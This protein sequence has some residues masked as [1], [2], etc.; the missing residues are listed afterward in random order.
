MSI[1]TMIGDN[2]FTTKV[3]EVAN[4]A[5]K[6]SL[7]P[8]PF[9]TACCAIEYMSVVSSHYDVSRFGAEVV[10]FSP[11]QSDLLM[12]MGTITDKMGPI[13]KKIYDQMSD[14]KWVISMGACATS[15]GFYRAYHV[16][17]GIDEII[18]VDVY[19]PGC[20]P[21]P[22][23]VIQAILMI[24]KLIEGEKEID[25]EARAELRERMKKEVTESNP[26][27]LLIAGQQAQ[28]AVRLVHITREPAAPENPVVAA[29]KKD[30]ADQ[31]LDVN[32]FRGDL[33]I[34]LRPDRITA[35]CAALKEEPTTR[36][37]MLST[38]TGVDYQGYP[39]KTRDERFNIVYQLYSVEHGHRVR[40]KV[41]VP[42]SAPEVDSVTPVWKTANWWERETFDMFGINFRRH[43]D[44]RRI[45]CHEEFVGHALRKD[46][47][48]GGRTP[49]SRDYKL[50]L[51]YMGEWREDERHDRLSGQPTI[52]NIGPSHPATHGTL[53]I[54]ARLDGEKITDA[55]VEIGYLHR[56]FE[57]MAETH[58]WNQVIPYTDR[59]NYMSS[60]LN[61]V[62][63]ACAV[64]KLLGIEVPKRVQYIRVIL[65]ELS[66][67][68]D[69]MV[70]IGTN[71]L[72]MGAITNFWYTFEPREEIYDLLEMTAGVRMMVSYVRVGGLSA[73][74]PKDFVPRCREV[75]GRLPKYIDDV[76]KLNTNSRIFKQRAIGVTP[77][78]GKDAIDW[79]ITGPMLRAAGVPYDVRQNHPYS[80]YEDFDFEV[81]IGNRGDVYDRYLVR[82]EEMRQSLR[83]VEQGIENLPEGPYQV[84]D[85][86]ITLPPKLGVYNNIEDLMNHFKL[87]MHGIQTPPGEVYGY[88]EGGNG[89]LGFYIVSD[90]SMRPWRCHARGPC[91]PIFSAFPKM[92]EGGLVADAVAALGSLNIVAG[93][94][95]R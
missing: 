53:R 35:I 18:P 33:T 21:T 19:I 42:E 56:C 15:G 32:D 30:F 34:V 40:L 6:N 55:D 12:V 5:R 23:A 38:I 66:R 20:P 69:H 24:R 61:N 74:L 50:P 46:H 22:E 1:E 80:S 57:K 43:P 54:V 81:P 78:S 26:K 95:D 90:G 31:I 73:D 45:L 47:E 70:C 11:R 72:D 3:S 39:E 65:G 76:H 37:D 75:L 9:G 13:L 16:M 59:L 2:F 51:E 17:Q 92:I 63:Y 82:M 83:I 64:E 25:A 14:P 52:I 4:W 8:M 29:I 62:G 27:E 41:P 7:W 94:L 48:P 77:I 89:E 36:F 87:V 71:L 44:L 84:D 79:G 28:E 86:R 49:L 68:M 58:Q 88:S 10:R 60:F 85:R 91:F 67:I 93:E